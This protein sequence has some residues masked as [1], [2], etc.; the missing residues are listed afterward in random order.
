MSSKSKNIIRTIILPTSEDDVLNNVVLDDDFV[1]KSVYYYEN[2]GPNTSSRGHILECL[3]LLYRESKL[4]FEKNTA[5]INC[6][7]NLRQ[8]II[9]DVSTDNNDGTNIVRVEKSV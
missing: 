4:D 9:N 1:S 7:P 8:A 3:R 2:A 5:Y 6:A